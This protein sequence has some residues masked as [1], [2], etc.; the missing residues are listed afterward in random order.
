MKGA[1]M[2]EIVGVAVGVVLAAMAGRAGADTHYVSAGQS[3]QAALDDP[4]TVDGDEIEV[5]PGT[6]YEAI[7]F[8]DKAVRLYSS[9]GAGVTTIDAN[10]AYHAVQCVSGEDANTILEGFTITGGN[11]NGSGTDGYG[12]GMYNYLSSPTVTNCTFSGNLAQWG[13]GMYNDGSG[14]TP[15]VSNC[16]FSGNEA[17]TQDGGGMGNTYANPTVT[18]CVFTGN[19]AYDTGGA[20]ANGYN[21]PTVTNCTFNQNVANGANGGGGMRN[22]SS[23]PTVTNC[24]LWGNTPDEISSGGTS[25]PNVTYSDIEGGYTGDGNI[26]LEPLFVDAN[27][28]DLRLVSS[29]SPC[30]DSGNND[31]VT[32]PNDLAGN[33]RIV[34]RD[35]DG[36]ATVDMGAYE[37]QS[38][39]IHNIS[40][41]AYYETIQAALDDP[42]TVDGDEIE[43]GP[44]TYYESID[45]G[46]KAITLRSSDP[47]DAN[48]VAA[49]IIDGTGHYHVVK[50]VS[51][52]DANT[53]LEGFTI[54]GGNANG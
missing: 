1:R 48:I 37:L 7:D 3:I 36:T 31:V 30:V 32:E 5:A 23:N 46:G 25:D 52:E 53:I 16:I 40:Q 54:T 43:V 9:G 50:C 39:D 28:G 18:N 6:Y 33:D 27:G 49:T 45:F 13:G 21:S 29:A 2:L 22:W 19:S 17:T 26:N 51:G 42:C 44:G 10:G 35:L 12:G 38:K 4:C 11:A 14:S 47:N 15:T 20:M 41:D 8:N 34:D 24:I